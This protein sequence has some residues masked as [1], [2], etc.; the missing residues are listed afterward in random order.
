MRRSIWSGVVSFGM[1]TIPVKGLLLTQVPTDYVEWLAGSRYRSGAT[2]RFA[3][4]N[5]PGF[6]G[7]SDR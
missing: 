2:K 5:C 7:D 4:V 3:R 6:D 1:V